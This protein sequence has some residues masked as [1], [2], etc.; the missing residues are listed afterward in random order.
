MTHRIEWIDWAKT[1]AICTVV[2]IHTYCDPLLVKAGN[3]YVMP[4]FFFLSG[5]LFSYSRNPSFPPFALKRIRQLLV[6]YLWISIL[7]YLAW[8]LVLRHYGADVEAAV[9][10]HTPLRAIFLGIA[11]DM[12]HDIPMWSILSFFI[13]EMAY[14]PIGR[15]RSVRP[16]QI[17]VAALALVCLLHA[18]FGT[19]LSALPFIL[20]PSVAG[21]GF[22]AAG[23]Q[24]ALV[25][26]RSMAPA[27][28]MPLKTILMALTGGFLLLAAGYA[29]NATVSF[30]TAYFGSFPL[31]LLGAVGGIVFIVALSAL[32]VRCFGD[33]SILRF[34]SGATLYICGFHLLAFAAIKGVVLIGLHLNPDSL[35]AGLLPGLLFAAAGFLLTLPAAWLAKK[36]TRVLIG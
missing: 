13:V 11:P 29:T 21:L 14:Y 31:F 4:L 2:V 3:A 27:S 6:P 24:T 8:L 22:Y 15:L 30:Y 28:P 16:W 18:I 32:A 35:T 17:C 34:I 19:R 33:S 36:F 5:Y 26:R 10:W 1:M 9:E 7:A 25:R 20:I 12:V 23:H